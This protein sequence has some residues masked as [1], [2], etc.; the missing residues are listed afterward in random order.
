M[1]IKGKSRQ[2][3]FNY[4]Y[5]NP[6]VW[7]KLVTLYDRLA[8]K[9]NA[10]AK[11]CLVSIAITGLIVGIRE[12]GWL[13][14]LEISAYDSM[15]QKRPDAGL[16]PRLLVVEITEKD[17]QAGKR[18]PLS[19]Q[20]VSQLLDTLNKFQPKAIGLD[21]YRDI[22]QEPGYEQ[23]KRSLKNPKLIVVTSIGNTIDEKVPPPD[24]I[25]KER[26]GFSDIASDPDNVIR[27]NLMLAADDNGILYSFSL[28]LALLYLREQGISMAMPKSGKPLQ[29][30]QTLFKR[31]QKDDGGYE[32]IDA[33][34]GY[35][36]LL[37]YR[38]GTEIARKVTLSQVLKEEVNPD[39]IK[40]KIVLIG[41]TAPSGKDLFETPYSSAKTGNTKMAGVLIHAQMTSQILSAVLDDRPLFSFWQEWVEVIW[42]AIWALIG[43][44]LGWRMNNP[45]VLGLGSIIMLGTLFG[46]GYV[47]FLYA[48]W[49]PLA[50]PTLAA[51][52]TGTTVVVYQL[53]QATRQHQMMMKLLGQ[54]TS[55][56]I[57]AAL[58][59]GRDR[60]LNQGILPGQRLTATM[61]MSDIKDFSTISED[62]TPE[63]IMAWL[64]EYLAVM[65]HTI[66]SHQGV[67][68]KFTGDGLLAV[69]GVPVP[70]TTEAEIAK[71]AERAV[72]CALEI[73]KELEKLNRDWGD[74]D[75]PK[76]QM[77]IGIFT[78][79]IMVGSL[80]GK[81]RLEYGVIGDS[82]NI[83]SR[84]ESY[85]KD[86]Q[87]GICRI[88]IAQQTLDFLQ[89]EFT[90]ESW[91]CLELKGKHQKIEVYRVLGYA[92]DYI[93]TSTDEK[94]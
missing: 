40:D 20:V 84:L 39:W 33:N 94:I 29:I 5:Q 63:T 21:M 36:I 13:Q 15:V 86:R 35:Q 4:P 12:L 45:V 17:I 82:V 68:N 18:W 87:Q 16:D 70:R 50:A 65:I 3:K 47:L 14:P 77:R 22:P 23:L 2:S 51:I 52:I 76:I 6:I 28:R 62:R 37:N 79:P 59:H 75:L 85:A 34:G 90:V 93:S 71:D 69:F 88:L 7:F 60:L 91:G 27:R 38:S 31:L 9:I 66:Q 89:D 42:I 26:I 24:A 46:S 58:W 57:A 64:N 43:G 8:I 54:Q 72:T 41:T 56:E 55:P 49:I 25:P 11:L 67:I 1:S 10:S 30:H 44:L 32:N 74:R 83:A 48:V 53:K 73:A 78:G 81:E 61:L 19:D 92:V 80:G